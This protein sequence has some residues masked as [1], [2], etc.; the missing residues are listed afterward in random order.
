[1]MDSNLCFWGVP[2]P[3]GYS[4]P[5]PAAAPQKQV[6]AA[7]KKGRSSPVCG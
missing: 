7:P 4:E 1:M 2:G 5:V 3:Q 6:A